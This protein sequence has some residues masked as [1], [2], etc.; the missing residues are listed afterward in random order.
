MPKIFH[1][2]DLSSFWEDSE[3][4]REQW[5]EEQ[6][7]AA[8]IASVEEELGFRLPASYIGLMQVQNGGIPSN[9]C[10]PTNV[11]TSWAENHVAITGIMGIGRKKPYSLCG[12]LGSMF[13]Q[14]EWG[15]PEFGVC[16]CDCPSAGH[17]M[18]M[19]DY[20]KCGKD[21]EPEVIHVDQERDFKVT[22][23]AKDFETFIRGLVNSS[24]YDTSAED[25]R[26][27][28]DSIERGKFSTLLT[29]LIAAQRDIDFGSIIRNVCRSVA[30]EKGCFALHADDKS[31]LMY[32][33]QFYL[34][35]S[36]ER[37]D[38]DEIF[39]DVYPEMLAFGDGEVTTG[40]YAPGFVED[41][42]N[43]RR[44]DRAIVVDPNGNLHFSESYMKKFKDRLKEFQ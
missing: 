38:D 36:S 18:I 17:D 32:D 44:A 12:H 24:V 31:L 41:W 6:P 43:K 10:F 14:E 39:L 13:M 8:M 23:L 26:K 9:T 3:Y 15:Y 33:I 35:S 25:L 11:A 16:V 28:L 22:P 40:G 2:F 29:R 7:T 21:G 5:I 20:R 19:L 1:E 4:A 37:V 34:Y 42:L 27:E 30:T